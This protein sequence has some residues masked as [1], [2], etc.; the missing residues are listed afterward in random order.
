MANSANNVKSSPANP[1]HAFAGWTS[2]VDKQWSELASHRAINAFTDIIAVMIPGARE[3]VCKKAWSLA[4]KWG[5][6]Q[7]SA[8][9]FETGLSAPMAAMVNGTS[10]HALDF[11]DNFDPA[12]AHATAVLAPALLALAEDREMNGKQLIDAYIV[13]LQIIRRVGQGVNPFH[14]NRGL[15]PP[16]SVRLE[17][18]RAVHACLV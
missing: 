10:A 18:L 2:G 5:E 8:V 3:A 4:K 6:G 7:C 15:P 12:K 9:G 14:R 17:A 11:D 16:P 13:G 1:L